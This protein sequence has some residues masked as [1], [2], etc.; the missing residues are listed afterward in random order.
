MSLQFHLCSDPVI[1]AHF[2]HLF[3]THD[4]ATATGGVVL[5][6]LHR[7]DAS[8]F[9][10]LRRRI[11]SIEFRTFGEENGLVFF[12]G[13]RLN[14]R[15]MNERFDENRR[16]VDLVIIVG[17]SSGKRKTWLRTGMDRSKYKRI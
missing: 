4:D 7:T 6:D 14:G 17:V 15:E 16:F 11:V 12:A 10:L 9:H 8:L 5:K 13:L 2:Q 1:G 3:A